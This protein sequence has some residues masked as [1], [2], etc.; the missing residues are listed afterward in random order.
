MARKD[1]W[2]LDHRSDL[3]GEAWEAFD[4]NDE[5]VVVHDSDQEEDH[6]NHMVVVVEAPWALHA[7]LDPNKD[8]DQDMGSDQEDNGLH[9]YYCY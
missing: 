3:L 6:R 2:V 9:S 1:H 4:D 8:H 5:V 7:Y